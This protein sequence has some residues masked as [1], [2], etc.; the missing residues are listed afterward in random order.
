MIDRSE[1]IDSLFDPSPYLAAWELSGQDVTLTIDYVEAG[2]VIGDGGKKSHK[3]LIHF[4]EKE[5]PK[6]YI[7]NQTAKKLLISW[8]G[9]AYRNWAGK[10]F[11]VYPTMEKNRQTKIEEEVIRL[12][13]KKP[14]PAPAATQQ[15]AKPATLQDRA[16]QAVTALKGAT[17]LE[18]LTKRT[19]STVPLCKEL[20]DAGLTD[21][22][23]AIEAAST[24]RAEV[25]TAPV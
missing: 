15:T 25:L 9:A 22:V 17:S 3:P 18:Q 23:N 13:P 7:L 24:E 10:R 8:Y 4:V 16:Q 2:E 20:S 21:L 14:G 6:P 19:A 11:T 1:H 5:W 12:R